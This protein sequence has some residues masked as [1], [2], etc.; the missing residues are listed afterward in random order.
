VIRSFD[1][2]PWES[3]ILL[4]NHRGHYGDSPSRWVTWW[5]DR[6]KWRFR[7]QASELMDVV[8]RHLP[9]MPPAIPESFYRQRE[10]PCQ[11]K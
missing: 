7:Q 9:K 4:R 8:R 5:G 11:S 6:M 1:Q 3:P 2:P 10:Q